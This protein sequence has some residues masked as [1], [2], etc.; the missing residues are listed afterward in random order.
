MACKEE[1]V[2]LS[3]HVCYTIEAPAGYNL[4]E[5]HDACTDYVLQ[6]DEDMSDGLRPLSMT[7]NA[8]SSTCLMST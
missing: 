3:W 1:R 4:K 8:E 5:S 2:E 6:V 7:K